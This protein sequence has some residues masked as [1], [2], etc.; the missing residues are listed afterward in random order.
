MYNKCFTIYFVTPY[1][2]NFIIHWSKKMKLSVADIL[3]KCEKSLQKIRICSHILQ[4]SMKENFSIMQWF[5]RS[6]SNNYLLVI[7]SSLIFKLVKGVTIVS[8]VQKQPP[9][10]V[11]KKRCS[12]N[13]Q[14]IYR[15]TPIPKCDFN[16]VSEQLYWNRTSA[17]VFSCKFTA[18]F[19]NTFS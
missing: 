15:R 13:M 19:P 8:E 12:E 5:Y 16:K 18:Y 10:G 17:R 7:D 6:F 2:P 9:I 11:F 3:R 14:Q 4:K 1:Y